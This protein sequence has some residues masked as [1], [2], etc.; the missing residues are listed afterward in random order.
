MTVLVDGERIA[1]I[2]PAR[3]VVVPTGA[4]QINGTGKF[5]IPGL[6][7]LHVH[8]SKARASAMQLLVAN[9]VTTVRDM[10]GDSEE[11]A[12]WRRNVDSGQTVGPR[13]VMAG[14]ILESA[15]NVERMRKDPGMDVLVGTDT[16]VLNV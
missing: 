12:V 9:G 11:L 8:L 2:G 13:I 16:A 14:P 15:R 3:E 6:I 5:L 10:G 7:D 4:R 1:A